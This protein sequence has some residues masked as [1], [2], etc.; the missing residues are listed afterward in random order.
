[1][2]AQAKQR[3]VHIRVP[4]RIRPI[5]AKAAATA[6]A[7]GGIVVRNGGGWAVAEMKREVA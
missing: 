7:R 3:P 6:I 2:N 5:T 4:V 1:M